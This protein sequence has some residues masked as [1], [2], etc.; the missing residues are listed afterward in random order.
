MNIDTWL[1]HP[2]L[3]RLGGHGGDPFRATV[4]PIYLSA[5]YDQE[6]PLAFGTYDYSRGA[7]P[8]RD[9]VEHQLARL[10]NGTRAFAFPSGVAALDGLATFLRPG[11]DVLASADLYGGTFRLFTQVWGKR[12]IT[13]RYEDLTDPARIPALLTPKTKLIHVEPLGN[14]MQTVCDIAALARVARAHNLLLTVDS[15]SLTPLNIKPLDLGAHV[16]MQSATKYINGHS[17]VMAGV[18]TL[19]DQP[20]IDELAFHHN[21]EG[22]ALPPFECALMLRGMETMSL[23]LERAQSNA[24]TIA[25]FL[26]SRPD[27]QR[28]LYVG[29]DNHPRRDIHTA[30]SR[31]HGC[32]LSFTTGS[33]ERSARIVQRL[34]LFAIRVSFGSVSSSASMPASMSHKSVPAHLRDRYAP[35]ADLVRL[36]IGIEHVDD[37]IADLQAA[38]AAP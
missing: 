25:R 2:D 33:V 22:V 30:Q 37:L 7:N 3:D 1:V 13:V 27:V 24:L 5:T 38:F 17:D 20:L 4:P 12:G 9:V 10:E 29:L 26:A 35:P 6:T 18:L 34:K 31:G 32:V 11:D 15:T 8:T 19:R 36:S 21:A 23:R 28:V 16:V 14:P